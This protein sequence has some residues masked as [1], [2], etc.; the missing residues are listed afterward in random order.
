MK[1]GEHPKVVQERLGHATIAVT[2]DTCNH[3]IPSMQ[4]DASGKAGQAVRGWVVRRE[5]GGRNLSLTVEALPASCTS[6]RISFRQG[7]GDQNVITQNSHSG[8]RWA[9]LDWRMAVSRNTGAICA[10]W[11]STNTPIWSAS[12]F[13]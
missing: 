3:V 12:L 7:T 9:S 1:L 2:M 10:S 11:L 6:E 4:R 8:F 5:T 13:G